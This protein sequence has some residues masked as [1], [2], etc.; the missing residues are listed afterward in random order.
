MC[1]WKVVC[2]LFHIGGI[3]VSVVAFFFTI[4][5]L[6]ELRVVSFLQNGTMTLGDRTI[7]DY[8]QGN[9]LDPRSCKSLLGLEGP[10]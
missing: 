8:V 3:T 6:Y 1:N 7:Y 9:Y 10:L 4:S 2:L 5:Y